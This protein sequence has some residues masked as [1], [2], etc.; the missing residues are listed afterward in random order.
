[1]ILSKIIS[2]GKPACEDGPKPKWQKWRNNDIS[3]LF[4]IVRKRAFGRC[5]V[6]VEPDLVLLYYHVVSRKALHLHLHKLSR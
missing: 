2:L 5:L 6:T 4:I 1:M 3:N